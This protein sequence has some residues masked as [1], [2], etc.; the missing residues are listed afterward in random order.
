[1]IDPK[2]TRR[3]AR[4]L[5][6]HPV[7]H[8]QGLGKILSH[9]AEDVIVGSLF[10]VGSPVSSEIAQKS[11]WTP[12]DD[13]RVGQRGFALMEPERHLEWIALAEPLVE[14]YVQHCRQY[15]GS[16]V[17]YPCLPEGFERGSLDDFVWRDFVAINRLMKCLHGPVLGVLDVRK[18]Y[19]NVTA[20]RIASVFSYYGF[21]SEGTLE[22]L[23]NFLAR[24]QIGL[25]IGFWASNLVARLYLTPLDHFCAR[26]QIPMVRAQDDIRVHGDDPREVKEHLEKIK[27]FLH[28]SLGLEWNRSK[29]AVLTGATAE[30]A[31]RGL[32]ST[33]PL[34]K[35]ANLGSDRFDSNDLPAT[36][37]VANRMPSRRIPPWF[38]AQLYYEDHLR[39]GGDAPAESVE[40]FA[41]D[42][43]ARE[44]P[45]VLV[46]DADGLA[47]QRPYTV[48]V[49]LEAGAMTGGVDYLVRMHREVGDGSTPVWEEI[50]ILGLRSSSGPVRSEQFALLRGSTRRGNFN[51][52][53]KEA[54]LDHSVNFA[55][56]LTHVP[57]YPWIDSSAAI[58]RYESALDRGEARKLRLLAEKIC[59]RYGQIRELWADAN[60]SPSDN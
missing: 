58:A 3:V 10:A 35:Y 22:G 23:C 18:F 8:A 57:R 49:L 14:D 48:S 41:L 21:G 29:T 59:P 16:M 13:K 36:E 7:A 54:A 43:M 45:A 5:S 50:Q 24:G 39:P 33:Q 51:A 44:H 26:H 25:P 37:Y 17:A 40:R 34:E 55:D 42:V 47:Q 53:T 46:N 60:M 15:D 12:L 52:I 27:V 11:K 38:D 56:V 32:V 9:H 31:R 1:M 4:D 2:L 6:V 30:L 28:D 20:N 19:P